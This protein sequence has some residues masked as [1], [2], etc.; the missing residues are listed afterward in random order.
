MKQDISNI[1]IYMLY[2]MISMA[3]F[4]AKSRGLKTKLQGKPKGWK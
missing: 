2:V 1:Y 3:L 4:I